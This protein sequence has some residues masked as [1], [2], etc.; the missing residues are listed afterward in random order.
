MTTCDSCQELIDGDGTQPP[1]AEMV[2]IDKRSTN[3]LLGRRS[4]SG[5]VL[6]RHAGQNLRTPMTETSDSRYGR[7]SWIA[8]I[9]HA[10]RQC[11]LEMR[12]RYPPRTVVMHPTI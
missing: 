10:I 6:A 8:D 1:H 12:E 9:S 4:S 7:W 2:E 5:A 11:R 3:H